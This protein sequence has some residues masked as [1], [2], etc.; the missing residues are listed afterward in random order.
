MLKSIRKKSR[1]N[2]GPPAGAIPILERIP[3]EITKA[4][5]A[6]LA[7]I[8]DDLLADEP[9]LAMTDAFGPR[10]RPGLGPGPKALIGDLSEIPL[11][12]ERHEP[13]Y[14]YRIALLA[15]DRDILILSGNRN[16]EFEAYL[17]G[18]LEIGSLQVI[19][20][21]GTADPAAVPLAKRCLQ[22]SAVFDCLMQAAYTSGSLS[23]VSH[24]TTGHTW[25]LAQ[26]L[27]QQS[28]AELFVCGPPPRL[29]RRVNDKLWFTDCVTRILGPHKLPLTRRAF[30]PAALAGLVMRLA[31]SQD[32]L[33]VK[34]PDSAGSAGNLA[35]QSALIRNMPLVSVRDRLLGLLAALGWR[36]R[37]PLLVEVWDEPIVSSPSVQVW[38]SLPED[39]EPVVEGI[40]EQ[41]VEGPV[42]AFTGAVPASMPENLM[43]RLACDAVK[44]ALVFQRLG[45]FG[46]CSFD[47][48][49]KGPSAADGDVHWIECNGRWGGVSLPMTLANRLFGAAFQGSYVI[50]QQEGFKMPKRAFAEIQQ[51]LTGL[52]YDVKSGGEGIILLTTMG[53]ERGSGLHF[54]A[55]APSL[56]RAK[57]LALL[58]ANR[59]ISAPGDP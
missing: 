30:G 47:A 41:I 54:M 2:P 56:D 52:R 6:R 36:G 49:I 1:L 11:L 31:E 35:I 7:T 50:V 16:C 22:Q 42:G 38:I 3:V 19:V 12:P 5:K 15:H 10:V 20:A 58:A 46:R 40:F 13:A 53:L 45:Y 39:G 43:A 28:G 25:K 34:I 51:I 59:L 26:A 27:A 48:I 32:K 55:V 9:A 17:R 29:S 24:L 33:V 14:E 8:A 44:L 18:V 37:Y 4:E 21:D 57:A 23:I